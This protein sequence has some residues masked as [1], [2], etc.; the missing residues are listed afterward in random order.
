PKKI[1]KDA[2]EKLEKLLEDA[3]D[4]GEELA[5]DIAEE[6]AR[7]AEKALKELLRE[8]ASP[9]L[10]VDL[11]ETALRA[12]LEIAKDG[13]EELALDIARIL[14]KL[15]EV[16]LEVLLKDGASPKLIV[17]LAKTALR[18]LLEIAEDGGEELALDIAEIL[19]ELAEVALRVLLKDGASPKLIE[20]LAKTALDALEEIAR[21][22]GEELAEDIDRILRKLEKVA[23]DVLRKD[24]AS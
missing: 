10:I 1:V 22:G 15:A 16:A 5:L 2:K 19:A 18:A 11:A 21:D 7:E 20:D 24:G 17:D 23:R 4:G 8:G 13:G 12:L 6:L 3:K 14:A 9:E